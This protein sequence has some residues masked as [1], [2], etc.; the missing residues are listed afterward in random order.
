M[1]T[2]K[3][4]LYYLALAMVFV[5]MVLCVYLTINSSNQALTNSYASLT[6]GSL[7]LFLAIRNGS[8]SNE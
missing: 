5:F 2:L 8:N 3:S 1:K 7:S 4:T 6:L